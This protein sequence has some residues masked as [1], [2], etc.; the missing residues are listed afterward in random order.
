M[1]I[2]AAAAALGFA[3]AQAPSAQ[4]QQYTWEQYETEVQSEM[5]ALGQQWLAQ[6]EQ[7]DR[8]FYDDMNRTRQGQLDEVAR[9]NRLKAEQ[10]KYNEL[11]A[12]AEANATQAYALQKEADDKAFAED[13]Q[14]RREQE[15][16]R[17]RNISVALNASKEWNLAR[18]QEI[19][20]QT[21]AH[22]KMHDEA[23]ATFT[24]N[25]E[26]TR[27]ESTAAQDAVNRERLDQ[28]A[29]MQER[30]WALQ[31][32]SKTYEQQKNASDTKFR[33]DMEK[34]KQDEIQRQEDYSAARNKQHKFDTDREAALESLAERHK[35][36][37]E[38]ADRNFTL[39]MQQAK[40]DEMTRQD[41]N[42][43]ARKAQRQW[44]SDRNQYLQELASQQQQAKNSS[45][46]K[47]FADRAEER[48][49][50][51]SQQQTENEARA[52][53]TTFD[54]ERKQALEDQASA[55]KTKR[56]KAN[57][58]YRDGM[59][60]KKEQKILEV[61]YDTCLR[62]GTAMS[63]CQVIMEQ[64]QNHTAVYNQQVADRRADGTYN[65]A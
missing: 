37:K 34:A 26:K 39:Q 56:E 49:Q 13:M 22:K 43:E 62:K 15:L 35:T 54:T 64:K 9:L 40:E 61:Q 6:K 41:L 8:E 32:M 31:N 17:Q 24:A 42:N 25:M 51:E 10:V 52:N 48:R 7:A 60:Y 12:E 44:E 50:A 38:E 21:A 46:T 14:R 3:V 45:D 20:N 58:E 11:K 47:F 65:P 16:E 29:W 53:Q 36:M 33:E 19:A 18:A 5:D 55:W 27:N 1:Q 30:D 28:Q 57:Q 4:T 23:T 59:L 2:A 63:S